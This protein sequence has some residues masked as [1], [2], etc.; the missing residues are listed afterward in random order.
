MLILGHHQNNK[1]NLMTTF[2]WC[3]RGTSL[4]S[5]WHFYS[6]LG[7]RLVNSLHNFWEFTLLEN[8]STF[9]AQITHLYLLPCNT[10]FFAAH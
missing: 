8:N 6:L 3:K 7:V 10:M 2:A 4:P 5:T 9:K 1:M